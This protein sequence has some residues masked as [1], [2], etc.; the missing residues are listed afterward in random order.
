MNDQFDTIVVGAGPAGL[1]AAG[2]CAGSVLVLERMARPGLKLLATGG[3]RCNITH[4]TD[5]EGVMRAFGREG[6]FMR[7]ALTVGDPVAIREFLRDHGVPTCVEP[8]GSVF[9]VSQ[10]ARDVLTALETA[11]RTRG[12]MLR[13]DC[14]VDRLLVETGRV[15]G[16]ATS[17]GV[18][19]GGR[20]IL[21]AGGRSYPGLGS[22]GSGFALASQAG[23]AVTPPVPALA[24]LFAAE[25]WIESLAGAVLENARVRLAVRGADPLGACGPVLFTHRG[26][27]GPPAL[28]V[29]GEIA[30]RLSQGAPAITV[31][32]AFDAARGEGDWLAEFETWRRTAGAKRVVLQLSGSMT[33][34]LAQTCCDV[35][36][37]G[38]AT[39][40]RLRKDDVQ[41][42]SRFL[43]GMPLVITGTEGWDRAMVTRGGVALSELDPATLASRR[44]P[45]LFCAGELVDLD[46][47]C[48]GYNLTWALASGW[49]AGQ[50]SA[51]V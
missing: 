9:P 47:P 50:S 10:R 46:G 21:A 28:A 13:T 31:A 25:S 5:A 35:T 44:V 51:S 34:R 17:Q 43:A 1:A 12:A 49:L 36:A 40:A 8:D 26:I 14:R 11:A 22:D 42:L 20:V 16:V 24:G 33:R 41:R 4:E 7:R 45:G 30:A 37:I 6:R 19:R 32:V 48:G 23:L 18:F 39:C 2:V 15:V 3:G 29:S 38:D 27:S